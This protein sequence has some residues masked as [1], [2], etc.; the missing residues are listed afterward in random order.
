MKNRAIKISVSIPLHLL[1]KLDKIT[2]Y[3]GRS[4]SKY[5]ANAVSQR[6]EA[7]EVI[8]EVDLNRAIAII[9][10][11]RHK[12]SKQLYYVACAELDAWPILDDNHEDS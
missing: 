7:A 1:E 5:I 2:T 12:V 8:P 11:N 9:M 10:G 4:R 3:K 6:I